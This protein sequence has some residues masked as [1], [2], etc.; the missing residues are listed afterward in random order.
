MLPLQ[1]FVHYGQHMG[2]FTPLG[3]GRKISAGWWGSSSGAHAFLAL[4]PSALT[5][6]PPPPPKL[7]INYDTFAF[8]YR[9]QSEAANETSNEA[10]QL[11]DVLCRRRATMPQ[12]LVMVV[13]RCWE[14]AGS[15]SLKYCRKAGTSSSCLATVGFTSSCGLVRPSNQY[16]SISTS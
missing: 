7:D 16:V 3:N 9:W 13:D 4:R 5:T 1:C 8:K 2:N 14:R 15:V 12:N 11:I 6:R 10:L